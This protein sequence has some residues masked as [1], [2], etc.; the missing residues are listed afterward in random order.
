MRSKYDPD[1]FKK[2]YFYDDYSEKDP[3]L[4]KN[5]YRPYPIDDYQ[6]IKYL[7]DLFKILQ[8]HVKQ[9]YTL[10][11]ENYN[12]YMYLAHNFI[13]IKS[14]NRNLPK[15]KK[16]IF[17][18]LPQ[19]L[20]ILGAYD[21]QRGIR[22]GLI[23]HNEYPEKYNEEFNTKKG[24]KEKEK[25][26]KYSDYYKYYNEYF[27]KKKYDYYKEYRK[28]YDKEQ[29]NEYFYNYSKKSK[30]KSDK[31]GEYQKAKGRAHDERTH[32]EHKADIPTTEISRTL[33]ASI[34]KFVNDGTNPYDLI[35]VNKDATLAEIKKA[36]RTAALAK[37]P[38]KQKTKEEKAKAEDVIK[39][40]NL[41]YEILSNTDAR[42]YYDSKATQSHRYR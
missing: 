22:E 31:D 14:F 41:A 9:S 17:A 35:G 8:D 37:H 29:E 30:C 6:T 12:A 38:D 15:I 34:D 3:K 23:D 16:E 42:R 26:D 11:D 33:L 20:E 18:M 7:D 24:T 10:G 13:E 32:E 21:I 5:K 28:D 2:D 1:F 36:Y 40:L 25:K 27:K 39:D 19:L 4:H